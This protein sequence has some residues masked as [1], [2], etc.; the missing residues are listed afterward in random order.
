V[1][2]GW[3]DLERAAPAQSGAGLAGLGAR[4]DVGVALWSPVAGALG[5]WR[6]AS[7]GGRVASTAGGGDCQ[8]AGGRRHAGT[9]GGRRHAR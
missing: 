5:W 6:P 9:V 4:E 8:H 7:G 1:V 2:P 3:P